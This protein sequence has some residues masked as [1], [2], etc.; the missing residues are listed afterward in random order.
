[1]RP[2]SRSTAT[3]GAMR[4]AVLSPLSNLMAAGAALPSRGTR[5]AAAVGALG[6][7]G[8]VAR[9]PAGFTHQAVLT[10]GL[11]PTAAIMAWGDVLLARGGKTRTELPHPTDISLN[12]L[13]YWTDNGA[14]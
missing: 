5:G 11:R 7:L 12:T 2:W 3:R 4:S 6:V 14:W 1:M 8:S 9:Y 13:G 10:A